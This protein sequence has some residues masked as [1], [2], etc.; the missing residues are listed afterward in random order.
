LLA[1]FKKRN[2]KGKSDILL[3]EQSRMIKARDVKEKEFYRLKQFENQLQ[4]FL[5]FHFV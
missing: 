3:I 5:S 2:R 1:N 4:F